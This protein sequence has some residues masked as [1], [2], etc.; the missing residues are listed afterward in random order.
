MKRR[1]TYTIE[2]L[3]WLND[4]QIFTNAIK[5]IYNE[6]RKNNKTKDNI[7]DTRFL[8][9]YAYQNNYLFD[10]NGNIIEKGD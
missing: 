9:R 3:A 5:N 2:E 8:V 10:A 1:K 7:S 4:K 6:V